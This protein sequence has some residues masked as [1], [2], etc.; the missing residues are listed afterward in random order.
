[1][2][3]DSLST[4]Q[5]PAPLIDVKPIEASKDWLALLANGG[6]WCID[7]DGCIS[8]QS[9]CKTQ[10]SLLDPAKGPMIHLSAQAEYIAIV[11]RFGLHG[12]VLETST[13]REVGIRRTDSRANISSFPI[14]FFEHGERTL[15]V[16]GT[17]WNHL[18]VSD[19]LTGEVLTQRTTER[20]DPD[21]RPPHY[22]D[23]FHCSLM[24]SPDGKWI[25]DNGWVWHPYGQVRTWSLDSWMQNAWESEDGP[26][27]QEYG[28]RDYFWDVGVCWVGNDRLAIWGEGELSVKP[29]NTIRIYDVRSGSLTNKLD[30]TPI[31]PFDPWPHGS[32]NPG[33]VYFDKFLFTVSMLS[34][35]RVWDIESGERVSYKK[36][37]RPHRYHRG[38]QAFLTIN[39]EQTITLSRLA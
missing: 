37:F 16:H 1:M 21:V 39:D 33:W 8:Q 3:F 38:S 22:L 15:L 23:Y 35:T 30:R 6:L 4:V 26:S 28:Y 14:A 11:E 34:G 17:E 32:G 36:S 5:L 7:E 27:V 19:L 29:K 24:V 13:M 2:Q 12:I 9:C 25:A 20:T 18:D 31:C 10:L